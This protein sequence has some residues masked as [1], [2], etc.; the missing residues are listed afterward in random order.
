MKKPFEPFR[1]EITGLHADGHGI[2]GDPQLR[3]IGALPGE[4]VTALPITVKKKKIFA[5]VIEVHNASADRVEPP[6]PGANIC[7][8]CSL[9][10][11][12]TQRQIAHKQSLLVQELGD[13]QPQHFYSPLM[14]PVEHYR[15]KAR[16]GVRF[17]EKKD[18]VLVG[19]RE[20]M[21]P[22]IADVPGCHTLREPVS[23]LLPQLSELISSLSISRSIPQIEVAVGTRS[24]ALV[25]RHLEELLETDLEL[26]RLFSAKYEIDI[27][28][29]PGNAESVYKLFPADENERL[30]Y[31]LPELDLSFSFH[32][33]DFTQINHS[34]NRAMVLFAIDLLALN[35]SDR[36]FDGFCGIGN[37]SLALARKAAFVTGVES[38]PASID[39]AQENAYQNGIFNCQF[40][41]QDLFAAGL[42]IPGLQEANKVLLDP[43]R[44]GALQVCK[45]LATHP[46]ERV[47]YVS[48]NPVTFAS[49]AAFLVANGYRFEGVGVID[50]FPHTTHVE[51][52][53]CFSQS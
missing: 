4:V 18:R 53:G 10:H 16:L 24:V 49:D 31:E 37:F 46:V 5:K 23:A 27:Y 9:Q 47:V 13:T 1:V 43:P 34:I 11:L 30:V 36:V 41:V 42:E 26:F 8:G 25:F 51:S 2:T 44:S 29:Q 45:K 6:C 33:L 12:D 19:F 40:K 15:S 39:R 17:V 32:P 3:I 48:C 21:K 52:I 35:L 22:F 28:L 14:G 20:K 7:G 50:M 38:S